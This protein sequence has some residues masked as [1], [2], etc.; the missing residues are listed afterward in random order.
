ME[1]YSWEETVQK[2]Y[3]QRY[4]KREIHGLIMLEQKRQ[5]SQAKINVLLNQGPDIELAGPELIEDKVYTF[6]LEDMYK[7]AKDLEFERAA[8]LRDEI[9][10]LKKKMS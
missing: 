1:N 3:C 10:R 9:E 5:V 8:S 2:D 6:N 7:S 4:A